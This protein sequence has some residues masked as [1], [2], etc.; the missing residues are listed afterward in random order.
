MSY[1]RDYQTTRFPYEGHYL[2]YDIELENTI[3]EQQYREGDVVVWVKQASNRYI[4]E[5]LEPNA[6]DGFFAW[7]FFDGILMQKEY[8]SSY[9]FEDLAAEL[10]KADPVLQEDLEKKRAEDEDF[11]QS[12]RAQLD[13]IYKRS[14]YFEPTFQLYPVGRVMNTIEL[15][16]KE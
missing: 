11:A 6:P 9:V 1:I 15:P 5:T 2:H 3:M 12:A 16:T 13:F 4:V 14:P 10:L 8:F 7:N